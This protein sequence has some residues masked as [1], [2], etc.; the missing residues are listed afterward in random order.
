MSTIIFVNNEAHRSYVVLSSIRTRFTRPS[1]ENFIDSKLY[2]VINSIQ[3]IETNEELTIDYGCKAIETKST[4]FR[5]YSR[6]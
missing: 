3:S 1:V 2:I 6:V 4:S 5:K